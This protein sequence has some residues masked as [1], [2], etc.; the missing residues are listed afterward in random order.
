MVGVR[1]V[2]EEFFEGLFHFVRLFGAAEGAGL[3]EE[4]GGLGAFFFAGGIVGRD[5][6]FGGLGGSELAA[7]LEPLGDPFAR[8]FGV[9]RCLHGGGGIGGLF[10]D[11]GDD[12]LGGAGFAAVGG[13]GEGGLVGPAPFFFAAPGLGEFDGTGV[14]VSGHGVEPFEGVGDGAEAELVAEFFGGE[15]AEFW[16]AHGEEDAVGVFALGEIDDGVGLSV[17]DGEGDLLLFGE[18]IGFGFP[19]VGFV[20]HPAITGDGEGSLEEV[21]VV[22]DDAVG[23]ESALGVAAEVAVGDV[24]A[25]LDVCGDFGDEGSAVEGEVVCAARVVSCF[26]VGADEDVGLAPALGF[27]GFEILEAV[28]VGAVE[29]HDEAGAVVFLVAAG[30]A[31]EVGH[32]FGAFE[33]GD[34]SGLCFGGGVDLVDPGFAGGE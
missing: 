22:E 14:I 15:E 16:V 12:A 9:E 29:E 17:D 8:G 31:E 13:D 4:L 26:A 30:E 27:E 18:D 25:F 11:G 24:E 21:G 20:L 2:G 34:F 7:E 32:A 1:G 10:F 3:T 19:E 28:H 33:E 5:E 23:E 6:F